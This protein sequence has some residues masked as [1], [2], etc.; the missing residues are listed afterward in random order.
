MAGKHNAYAALLTSCKKL[1]SDEAVLESLLSAL[2]ALSNG[3]PDLLDEEGITWNCDTLRS[4]D[5]NPAI[6]SLLV[7]FMRLNCLKHETN[8]QKYVA[9][10]VVAILSSTMDKFKAHAS[11]LK[12]VCAAF[13]VLTYDDDV[14]VPFGKGHD[15]A[16]MI[17]TEENALKKIMDVCNGKEFIFFCYRPQTYFAKVMFLHLSVILLTGGGRAWLGGVHG[18]GGHVWP[19]GMHGRGGLVWLDGHAWQGGACVAGW[20]CMAG[21]HA[22]LGGVCGE[23]GACV[24]KG[25]MHGKGGAC[26]VCMPPPS[27][28]YGRSMR[29]RYASYWNAFLLDYR[30]PCLAYLLVVR[31]RHLSGCFWLFPR[32]FF[33]GGTYELSFCSKRNADWSALS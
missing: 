21:G 23:G 27:T 13:R 7:K 15:H 4:T 29:G 5:V 10:D 16:K 22:W 11:V 18:Q 28:R 6:A 14:R 12:E 32:I 1:Q 17:V 26:V 8:R 30:Y 20:A 33:W 3:Q 19:G 31:W 24:V 9:S 25:G 2:C